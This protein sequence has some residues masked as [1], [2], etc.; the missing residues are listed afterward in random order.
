MAAAAASRTSRKEE[1]DL[2]CSRWRKAV[3]SRAAPCSML[4]GGRARST[5]AAH[6]Y[7]KRVRA[8][9][10]VL[11]SVPLPPALQGRLVQRQGAK[12]LFATLE[13]AFEGRKRDAA[14]R[15]GL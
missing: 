7:A 4:S 9:S 2:A 6:A 13:P 1:R 14:A 3:A 12:A 15:R 5:A 11:M 10:S 8:A